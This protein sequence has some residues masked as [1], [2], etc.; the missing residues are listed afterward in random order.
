MDVS[1]EGQPLKEYLA[2][3]QK[4]HQ[5]GNRLTTIIE[6]PHLKWLF[7]GNVEKNVS[8]LKNVEGYVS[9]NLSL[10]KESVNKQISIN[11]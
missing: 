1:T 9:I 10:I 6:K 7:S 3:L 5:T 2:D 8:S 11:K 4:K